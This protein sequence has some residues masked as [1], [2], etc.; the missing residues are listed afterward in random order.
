MKP[1]RTS[2]LLLAILLLAMGCSAVGPDY[3]APQASTGDGWARPAEDELEDRALE[4]REIEGGGLDKAAAGEAAQVFDLDRW[5]KRFGDA[6]LERLVEDA[7]AQNLDIRQAMARLAEARGLRDHT[8]GRRLP[9]VDAGASVSQLRQSENGSL[10][11]DRIPGLERNQTLVDLGLEA[12]WQLDLFGRTRRALE[13]AEARTKSADEERR[14]VQLTVAAEVTRLYLT[15]RGGQRRLAAVE[16]ARDAVAESAELV[17][18][19]AAAG[20]VPR[21]ELLRVEAEVH[22]L[23]AR[24]PSLRAELQALAMS[25]GPLVGTLPEAQ[26]ELLQDPPAVVELTPFP[27][28]ERAELLRRRPDVRSAERRLAAATADIGLATAELYPRL[29]IGASGGFQALDGKNL[30]QASSL[31]WGLVPSISWRV[32]DRG[33]VRA[34]IRI[35]EARA[36]QA[37]L[38][39]EASVLAALSEAEV[40]LAR[41]RGGLEAIELQ[42]RAVATA[43]QRR[44]L[45]RLR[46]QAGD[47]PL[48]SLL[49][50]ERRLDDAE[51]ELEAGR[52]AAAA[53]LVSLIKALGGGWSAQG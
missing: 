33:R 48:L 39:W 3:V 4:D 38:A 37:A 46:H 43:A 42:G 6:T 29:S 31:T 11:I 7:L 51:A 18:A 1:Q 20:E 49:D 14:A 19:L 44:D 16:A 25:L 2:I 13:A 53:E 5:W 24:L 26:L 10:P 21:L 52:I 50:A 32:F 12:A 27:L 45:E 15:L 22:A 23:E 28:G 40:A 8:A 34:E 41:Y 30:L 36:Q 17:A 47:S 9:T 35:A